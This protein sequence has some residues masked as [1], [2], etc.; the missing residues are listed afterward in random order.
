M[1]AG[2]GGRLLHC[3]FWIDS[4]HAIG[5]F[6]MRPANQLILASFPLTQM[7]LCVCST[8][9]PDG[10]KLTPPKQKKKPINAPSRLRDGQDKESVNAAIDEQ[11]CTWFCSPP[12]ARALCR[13]PSLRLGF[14]VLIHPRG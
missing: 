9:L 10:G 5:R 8:F 6:Y 1:L 2:S 7:A 3:C 13:S 4:S 11:Q 14:H 12:F